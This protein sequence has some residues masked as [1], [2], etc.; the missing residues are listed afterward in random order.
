MIFVSLRRKVAWA[1]GIGMHSI[2]TSWLSRAGVC[3]PIHTLFFTVHSRQSI[4]RQVIFSLLRWDL[5]RLSYGEAF[6]L[7]ATFWRSEWNGR[8]ETDNLFTF[9]RIN[10][11]RECCTMVMSLTGCLRWQSWWTW[12]DEI[13]DRTVGAPSA[14]MVKEV[15]LRNTS[16]KDQLWWCPSSTGTFTV[17]STY[18]LAIWLGSSIDIAESPTISHHQSFWRQFWKCRVPGKAK[19]MVWRAY[20]N[21]LPTQTNLFRRHVLLDPLCHCLFPGGRRCNA[22]SLGLPLC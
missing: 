4:F 18:G 9:G 15:P 10:G 7:L 21:T 17:C 5:I 8:L 1:F 12:N 13:L 11:P 2:L 19:H 6:W 3:S 16:V 22:C 20:T 14:A